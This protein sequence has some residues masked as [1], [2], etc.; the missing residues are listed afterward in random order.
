MM[1]VEQFAT[2]VITRVAID[3][4]TPGMI[5]P[6]F[7][8]AVSFPRMAIGEV[9]TQWW[10]ANRNTKILEK[11]KNKLILERVAQETAASFAAITNRL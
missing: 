7:T 2:L 8:W 5:G 9:K 1:N 10:M 4:A 11:P 3:L 6:N